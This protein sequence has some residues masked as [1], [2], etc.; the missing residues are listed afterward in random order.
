MRPLLRVLVVVV[1]ALPGMATA[2]TIAA[3][4]IAEVKK[5]AE[6]FAKLGEP[7]RQTGKPPRESDKAA[8]A[9]MDAVFDLRAVTAAE[10]L[11]FSEIGKVNDW[12][13]AILT[14]GSVFILSG[15]GLADISKAGSDPNLASKVEKNTVDF[16]PELGRYFDA[17][18]GIASA[19]L[20]TVNQHLAANP[21]DREK[22]NFKAGLPDI[23]SGTAQTLFS[24]LTTLPTNGLTDAWRAARLPAIESLS[25]HVAA[26]LD[27]DDLKTIH[28][29]CLQLAQGTTDPKLQEGLRRIAAI[30]KR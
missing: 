24:T 12:N 29:T 19:M 25:P 21:G 6:A 27:A 28:D 2:G 11:P 4:K 15:T 23:Y 13:K 8:K 1:L 26:V 7:S 14:V 5:A 20:G 22:P 9:L 17:Q 30:F 10:P 16:A 3:D 18:L